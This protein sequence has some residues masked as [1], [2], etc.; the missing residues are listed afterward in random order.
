MTNST[1]LLLVIVLVAI[2]AAALIV[3]ACL[4]AGLRTKRA[5]YPHLIQN[6][7]R[8]QRYVILLFV[9]GGL[10]VVC[11][12]ISQL[13]VSIQT[14][15]SH[16]SPTLDDVL[17]QADQE[18]FLTAVEEGSLGEARQ[19]LEQGADPNAAYPDDD[20]NALIM[21]CI[22]NDEA[23]VGLLLEYGADPDCPSPDGGLTP[24]MY[25]GEN[26]KVVSRLIE[27]GADVNAVDYEGLYTPLTEACAAYR[28]EESARLLLKNGADVNYRTSDGLTALTYLISMEDGYDPQQIELQLTLVQ[29]LID[30]GASPDSGPF[31]QSIYE[32][33]QG[34]IS[35][36]LSQITDTVRRSKYERVAGE[37][38][39]LLQ[40]ET[41]G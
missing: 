3:A 34:M 6:W 17:G 12:P 36:Q 40:S 11:P 39:S 7:Q 35:E 26:P 41:E 10:L 29:L 1:Q 22:N 30:H 24:L 23:M 37:L 5:A 32:Y 8:A 13:M 28:S 15:S 20:L 18:E 21:A 2:G 31:G 38:L 16:S 14:I 9:I 19:Q 27:A 25:A 4:Q 33:A